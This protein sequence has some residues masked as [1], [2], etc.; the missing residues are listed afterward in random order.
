MHA[1]PGRVLT[2]TQN[3]GGDRIGGAVGM[4][5]GHD[6]ECADDKTDLPGSTLGGP[7]RVQPR[8]SRTTM[9]GLQ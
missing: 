2:R 7:N 3:P 1:V 6:P 9:K 4:P 5:P 8:Q